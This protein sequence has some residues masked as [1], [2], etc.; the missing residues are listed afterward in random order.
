PGMKPVFDLVGRVAVPQP[1]SLFESATAGARIGAHFGVATIDGFGDFT[2]AELSA[3]SGIIAYVEK[4]QKAARPELER[5]VRED[6]AGTMLIDPA[7]RASLELAR[8]VSGKRAGSLLA[9]IDC[10]VTG[11]G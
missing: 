10:T 1:P 8:T 6:A 2:R 4:T 9:T 3:I 11:A 7:T 5:P